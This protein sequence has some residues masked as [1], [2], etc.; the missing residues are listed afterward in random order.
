[1]T[2]LAQTAAAC[3]RAQALYLRDVAA[4]GRIALDWHALTYQTRSAY[5]AIAA[6]ELAQESKVIGR[7]T[8]SAPWG[9][10]LDSQER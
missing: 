7:I 9:E 3:R 8:P 1:M 10:L 2:T 5:V 6:L 4:S